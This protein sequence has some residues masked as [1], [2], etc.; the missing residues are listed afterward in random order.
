MRLSIGLQ[1]P[2]FFQRRSCA[3]QPR[4]H[5]SNGQVGHLGDLAITHVLDFPRD[6]DLAIVIGQSRYESLE[7]VPKVLLGALTLT[8]S[9]VAV[10][11]PIAFA[12]GTT[13]MVEYGADTMKEA[14]RNPQRIRVIED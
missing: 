11:K 2:V 9:T 8:A 3:R 1:Q 6:Q 12:N 7:C 5:G 10:A 14:Q 4:H 13:V